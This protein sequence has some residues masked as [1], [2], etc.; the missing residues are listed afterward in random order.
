[1]PAG[2]PP[3]FVERREAT[4]IPVALSVELAQG[5]GITRD[6]SAVGLSF[7]TDVPFAPGLPI[8][9]SLVL[10]HAH[11]ACAFR[12]HCQGK[13]VRVERR[14]G[15]NIVAVAAVAYRLDPAPMPGSA[16]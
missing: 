1:M 12:L 16:Q 3:T 10:E 8:D 9:L 4:R 6:V 5:R 13:V 7:E 14:K 15:R 2:E 11:P